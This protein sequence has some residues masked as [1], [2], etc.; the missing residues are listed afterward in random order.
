MEAVRTR[1]VAVGDADV[2]YQVVGD[3]PIDVLYFY[4]LGSHIEV[5][6]MM[7]G[8]QD[9]LQRLT[10]FGRVILFDRRGTGASDG[11]A[12]NAIPTSEEWTEDVL[13][14]LD[15]A[16]SREAVIIAA[17]DAGPVALLF[18]ALHPER[19]R[20]LV[21]VNTTARYLRD[22]DYPIGVSATDVEVVVG[23]LR[24]TWGTVDF[25]RSVNPGIDDAAFLEEVAR[26]TR[27]AATP[28]A[29][30]AQFAYILGHLDVRD[31]LPLVQA[32][33]R[34][35]H[36]R[37][38]AIVPLAHGRYLADHIAGAA[39][40]ELPG[41]SLSMTP[42]LD[43]VLDETVELATGERRELVVERVL[44]TVLVSDIVGSTE[45]AAALGDRRWGALLDEH[46]RLVRGQLYRFRGHEVKTTGDGFLVS[47]DGPARAIRC[48]EAIRHSTAG[49]G[50]ELRVGL[51]TG[52]C[53]IRDDDLGGLAV[54]IATRIGALAEPGE[55]VVSGTVK[56]LV[57][58]SGLAFDAR[59]EQ[60]LRGVPGVWKVFAVAAT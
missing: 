10:T 54:H 50:I 13:A 11:V 55:I 22:D 20:A 19:V 31:A 44:T 2:A 52:E 58:G 30:G 37:E 9:F 38:N 51:H 12:N 34:V 18:A 59:G 49:L 1:Y 48:A 6:R 42:N 8:F 46:D 36:V 4:G 35:L 16:G 45:H 57:V 39:L 40:V 27:F 3:G 56:D 53:E 47:F 17:V 60:E 24:D 33:T 15:A 25:A 32:P 43:A 29:A 7:P 26:W 28:R 14:V 41:G 21:L 5:L 23:A